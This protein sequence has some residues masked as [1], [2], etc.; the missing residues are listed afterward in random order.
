MGV[1]GSL[2]KALA[3]GQ[4]LQEEAQQADAEL[5]ILRTQQ[6]VEERLLSAAPLSI[7]AGHQPDAKTLD[8]MDPVNMLDPALWGDQHPGTKHQA[9]SF[10]MLDNLARVPMITSILDKRVLQCSEYAVPQRNKFEVGYDIVLRDPMAQTTPAA[11]RR[12]LE[13]KRWLFTCGDPR[14]QENSTFENYIK[15]AMRDSF[16]YDQLCTEIVSDPWSG[17]PAGFVAID[18]RTVRRAQPSSQA[19]AKLQRGKASYVQ[20]INNKQVAKWGPEEFIFGV[21]NPRTDIRTNGYGYP[22][23]EKASDLIDKL[24]NTVEYNSSNF[25]NGIHMA[26][27]MAITSAMDEKKF[28]QYERHIRAMMSGAKNANRAVIMQL[29][30]IMKD[31]VNWLNVSNTNKEM[32]YSDWISFL[33][34]VVCGVFQM[35]PAEIGFVFG[36]EGQSSSFAAAGPGERVASSKESGL[37]PAL[38]FLQNLLNFKVIHLL[39]EDFELRMVGFDEATEARKLDYYNKAVRSTMTLNEARAEL[40]LPALPSK[41]ASNGPLDGVF[42][43]A[44]QY[45]QQQ[46]QEM[47]QQQAMG[48][49]LGEPPPGVGSQ[50]PADDVPLGDAATGKLSEADLAELFDSPEEMNKALSWT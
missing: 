34:K 17:K 20:I 8:P 43:S 48:G 2:F 47:L 15:K 35:D 45:A 26:G 38:R 12:A 32:E 31:A 42:Q 50:A 37:R 11:S 22:E 44:D 3:Q 40:G 28:R 9:F 10:E 7:K 1:L 16:L 36:N 25:T 49:T 27:I 6:E 5:L 29:D 39:D 21:R 23:I 33:L 19:M 24:V 13:L 18:A 14:L 4:Q 41:A 46:E 30:P